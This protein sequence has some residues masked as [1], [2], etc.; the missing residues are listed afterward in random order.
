MFLN[1]KKW[2]N[3]REKFYRNMI[4]RSSAKALRELH[5]VDDKD[6]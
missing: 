4:N 1:L 2:M 5:D 6:D 3:M